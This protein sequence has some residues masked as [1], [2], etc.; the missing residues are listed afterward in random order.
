MP[1]A[2]SSPSSTA[3]PDARSAS[4]PVVSVLVRS[5]Q[6]DSLGATL[7]SIAAQTVTG[8][9]VLVVNARG[10]QHPD[11]PVHGGPQTMR[12]LHQDGG[13][14]DRPSAANLALEQ[15]RGQWLIFVDDDDQIDPD[16]IAR[17]LGALA[18]APDAVAAY[19]GVRLRSADGEPAGVLDEPFDADR[20]WLANFLPIHAV[21]FSRQAA[22][23]LRFDA[24]LP[25][26]EDWDF[27][28]Y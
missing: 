21:L 24:D 16:H 17:L 27:W 25:V 3:I 9:E 26:Y 19:A 5:M 15:A 23:G 10:G 18:S 8:M 11:L 12:L 22:A 20:L 7:G 28:E 6:R 13:R 2:Q 4:T 1:S 14:L